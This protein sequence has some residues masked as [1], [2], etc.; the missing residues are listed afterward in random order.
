MLYSICNC[1]RG[2]SSISRV[3]SSQK[4]QLRKFA[5][6]VALASAL[7]AGLGTGTYTAYAQQAPDPRVADLVQAGELR[8]GLGLGVLMSAIKDPITGELRG[9]ALEVGRALAARM[10]LKFVVVEYP[11]PGAVFE[12]IRINAWDVAFLVMDPARAEQVY[13]SQPYLQTD[14]TYLVPAGSVIRKVADADQPGVR[15]A[16]PRGDG[17]DLYLTRTL[18]RAELVRTDTHAAA[19]ELLRTGGADAKAS[20]RS[21][22]L[23]NSPELPG[24]RVLDDGFAV[25]FLAAL[26]PKG[27]A[28]RLAYVNEFI[29]E[30]KASGLIKRVIESVGLQGVQVAPAG[31]PGP[32]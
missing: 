13:F 8:V 3:P 2:P 32:K 7:E 1:I 10:G 24:S 31:K 12:G 4:R 6:I 26:V 17:S 19:L 9:V 16:V 15:I 21:V 20:P 11:R 28:E 23:E 29:E 25:I 18:K 5:L 27:R 22:L 14:F 30:A